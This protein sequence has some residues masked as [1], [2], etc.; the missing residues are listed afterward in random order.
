[1][2]SNLCL[3]RGY[4]PIEREKLNPSMKKGDA[5]EAFNIGL[6]HNR[7]PNIEDFSMKVSSPLMKQNNSFNRK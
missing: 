5:K 7:W 2:Y 6:E 3:I 4:V 1:M